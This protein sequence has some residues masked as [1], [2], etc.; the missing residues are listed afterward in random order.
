MIPI[1]SRELL[2]GVAPAHAFHTPLYVEEH[3]C[4]D[5]AMAATIDCSCGLVVPVLPRD[6]R[7]TGLS[8]TQWTSRMKHLLPV[9]LRT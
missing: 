3:R 4:E 9:R 7:S 5:G 1:T 8:W 2:A 6:V